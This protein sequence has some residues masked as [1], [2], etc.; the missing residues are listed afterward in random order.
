[1]VKNMV[2]S[3]GSLIVG[4]ACLIFAIAFA[5]I[6]KRISAATIASS[7]IAIV[8]IFNALRSG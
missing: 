3:I 4:I 7:I 2:R 1:M 8:C 6:N 5:V